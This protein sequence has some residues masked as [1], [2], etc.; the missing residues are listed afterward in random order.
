MQ[1]LLVG[2][3]LV[4]DPRVCHGKLTFKGTRVPVEAVLTFLAQ[5]ETID[6]ILESWPE[7]QRAAV[8]E[9][10]RLAA[11]AWPELLREPI[12]KAIRQLA[13][14]LAKRQ[15]AAMQATHEST[16]PGRSA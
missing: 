6:G 9:A 13:A 5:G 15:S 4:V 10:V 7:V 14:V 11:A 8:E 12:E 16:H 2:Q 3:F 1:P